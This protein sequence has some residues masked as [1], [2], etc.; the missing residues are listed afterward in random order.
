[1]NLNTILG[2]TRPS[3]DS[4]TPR[5]VAAPR[6]VEAPAPTVGRSPLDDRADELGQARVT[7]RQL[8]LAIGWMGLAILAVTC[9]AGGAFYALVKFKGPLFVTLD[10]LGHAN[11]VRYNDWEYTPQAEQVKYF[12]GEFVQR[13][14]ARHPD[15]IKRNFDRSLTFMNA[16]CQE[17]VRHAWQDKKVIDDYITNGTSSPIIEVDVDGVAIDDLTTAPYQAH[18]EFTKVFMANTVLGSPE[19]KRLRYKANFTFDFAKPPSDKQLK[20]GN[21]TGLEISNF[22][23]DAVLE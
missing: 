3:P 14:Y 7:I 8:T 17:R 15:T 9:V 20:N 23:E 21:P 13:Y 18:V 5:P 4:P 2:R 11:I 10:K 12:L 22:R 6:P 19:K 1:M 16:G